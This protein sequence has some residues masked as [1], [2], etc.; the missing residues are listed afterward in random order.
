MK[1]N[2]LI[3]R[4]NRRKK[5]Y[6]KFSV[7]VCLNMLIR[8]FVIKYVLICIYLEVTNLAIEKNKVQ[9]YVCILLIYSMK[10][11]YQRGL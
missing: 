4:I 2:Q 7:I 9:N 5:M 1:L 6:C 8:L 11:H 3:T 10:R